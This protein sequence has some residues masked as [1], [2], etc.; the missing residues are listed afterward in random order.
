[1]NFSSLLLKAFDAK[2]FNLKANNLKYLT[3]LLKFS[4]ILIYEKENNVMKV[5]GLSG[6]SGSGKGTVCRIFN[7]IGVP[8][9]DTDLVYHQ[10]T[11]SSGPCL[12]ALIKEFG[13]G[14][15]SQDGGLDRR[16]LSKRVFF[17]EGAEDRREKLNSI[18]HSF[19]LGEVRRILGR[20]S[21]DNK[22]AIVDVPLLFESGF[23]KECDILCCVVADKETR[24]KRIMAR[25][26][27]TR[28]HAENRI[29]SQIPD[30]R[31]SELCDI[32]I[33]NNGTEADLYNEVSL[34]YKKIERM[35]I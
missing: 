19:V 18:T 17:G 2:D 8:S 34:A 32:V 29:S 6:G 12:S 5:I 9:I 22:F 27:I 24:I 11:S 30:S 33:K 25:D 3:N 35:F 15:V 21:V 14:I 31:L 1:M 10:L 28:E 13:E 26:N 16:A 20:L 23:D 7:E 4:I